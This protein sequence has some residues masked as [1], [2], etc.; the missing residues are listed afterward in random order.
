[1]V[2]YLPIKT[3]WE[4]SAFTPVEV[5][6]LLSVLLSAGTKTITNFNNPFRFRSF[7][8]SL[9]VL[10][11]NYVPT[12]QTW[13]PES[14]LWYFVI[15]QIQPCFLVCMMP[16]RPSG[17]VLPKWIQVILELSC[18]SFAIISVSV[19]TVY[20]DEEH[21][22]FGF[23]K[24]S[25]VLKMTCWIFSTSSWWS[26]HCRHPQS[27]QLFKLRL[28]QQKLMIRLFSEELV[29]TKPEL[30]GKSVTRSYSVNCWFHNM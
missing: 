1:M 25:R 2:H 22:D 19:L 24:H 29:E 8:A 15:L 9:Y 12:A 28:A 16:V 17:E 6:R 5:N 18:C 23:K 13:Q 10:F 21:V 30:K 14:Y 26:D 27:T 4:V 20:W 3:L 7:M 11:G